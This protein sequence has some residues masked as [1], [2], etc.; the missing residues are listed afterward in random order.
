MAA[1][2]AAEHMCYTAI[3]NLPDE[4]LTDVLLRI[5][6]PAALVHAAA[7][8][9]RWRGLIASPTPTG[10]FLNHVMKHS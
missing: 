9:K 3:D 2:A 1:A 7:V 10:R 8:S 6:T 5:P 4:V